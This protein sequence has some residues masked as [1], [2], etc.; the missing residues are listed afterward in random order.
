MKLCWSR[1]LTWCPPSPWPSASS[2][3]PAA[4]AGCP[5]RQQRLE[6]LLLQALRRTPPAGGPGTRHL[7]QRGRQLARSGAVLGARGYCVF[8]LDYGQLPGVPFFHGLGPSTPP[9]GSWPMYVDRVLAATGTSKTDIVG[10]SQG[11]MMPRVL[12]E[13]PRRR[14]QGQRVGRAG[15]QQP[16]HRPERPDPAAGPVPR[17]QGIHR[18]LRPR[19]VRPDRRIRHPQPPQR[20]RR[21]GPRR[22]LHRHRDPVRRGRHALPDA[23][24][25]RPRCAQRPAPGP[26]SVRPV[27]AR[28]HRPGGQGRLPRNGQRPRPRPRHPDHLRAN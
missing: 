18:R 22:A 26:V 11:G 9:P 15:S 3:R 10:H 5:H 19:A 24:P 25:R 14:G 27:R 6:Q 7:R 1:A 12:P 20:G 17:R 21:H 4:S 16:R 23:V 8:S 13:V 28:R 2:R